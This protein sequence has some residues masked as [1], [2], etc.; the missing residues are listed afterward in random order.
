[1]FI[2]R[3]IFYKHSLFWTWGKSTLRLL[4]LYAAYTLRMEI[5]K[6]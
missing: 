6:I 4:K 2:D 1:M 5:G 3:F